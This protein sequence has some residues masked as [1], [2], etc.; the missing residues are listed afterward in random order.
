MIRYKSDD[1]T[2]KIMKYIQE[3]GTC[4][5]GGATWKGQNVIRI[6]IC[7]W[8]TTEE[9]VLVTAKIFKEALT[10]VDSKNKI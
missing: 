6:S 2:N 8:V 1:L 7:S 9:D 3:S 5:L 10:C 4:W